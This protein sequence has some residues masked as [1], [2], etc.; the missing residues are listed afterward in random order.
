MGLKDAAR[1]AENERRDRTAAGRPNFNADKT[2]YIT[3]EF[4]GWVCYEGRVAGDGNF[5]GQRAGVVSDEA[6]AQRWLDGD[7]KIPWDIPA[8]PFGGLV[9]QSGSRR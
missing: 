9:D 8:D 1:L 6:I 5:T 2:R 3:R 7:D 4:L